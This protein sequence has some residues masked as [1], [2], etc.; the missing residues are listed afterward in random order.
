[1][2]WKNTAAIHEDMKREFTAGLKQDDGWRFGWIEEA[3]LVN[4]QGRTRKELLGNLPSALEEAPLMAAD[5]GSRP[6]RQWRGDSGRGGEDWRYIGI[7]CIL[8]R[9]Q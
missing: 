1:L 9:P 4:C 2:I 7:R 5:R 6:A 3:P 8:A